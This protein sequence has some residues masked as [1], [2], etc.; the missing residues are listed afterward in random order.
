M[1]GRIPTLIAVALVLFAVLGAKQPQARAGTG[2]ETPV[3]PAPLRVLLVGNSYSMFNDLPDLLEDV[4][5]SVPNGPALDV[6]IAFQ[7]GVGLKTHWERG[8]ARDML[9]EGRYTHVVLQGH[10][11]AVFDEPDELF[12]YTVRFKRL[13]DD[14]GARAV[15][16]A[17]WA[18]HPSSDLYAL[19]KDARTPLEM[20]SRIDALYGEVGEHTGAN[21][22]PVGEA[23]LLA[24][25]QWPHLRLH[26]KDA[27]HP[28]RL[29]TYLTACVLYGRLTGRDPEAIRHPLPGTSPAVLAR[30]RAV[31][32]ESLHEGPSLDGAA[33]AESAGELGA[34]AV[35]RE[36][37][38][39][40]LCAP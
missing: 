10:S 30:M 37:A 16:F 31:A 26:R 38:A 4:A 35:S 7:G 39:S 40:L 29:G 27:S 28:T 9:R 24:A 8:L 20:Q 18:R 14:T 22:A 17:T 19:G 15:L 21:V 2:G 33:V 13:I 5:A 34:P 36:R 6:D 1:L 32:A 11:R 12:E 23:W 3:A 25:D